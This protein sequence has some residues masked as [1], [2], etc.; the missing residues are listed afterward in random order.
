MTVRPSSKNPRVELIAEDVSVTK[1]EAL[2]KLASL[3]AAEGPHR[4][5]EIF[6]A[7]A[8]RE[9]LGTTGLDTRSAFPHAILPDLDDILLAVLV[10]PSG[11]EFQGP[12][13]A[14]LL[15]ALIAPPEKQVDMLRRVVRLARAFEG[16]AARDKLLDAV[17]AE[18]A[19]MILADEEAGA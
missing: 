13:P 14:V 7:L 2:W 12:K 8:D 6:R 9:E 4:E 15:F 11:V 1:D 10:V 17:S 16:R 18:D 3:L 5:R 19:A